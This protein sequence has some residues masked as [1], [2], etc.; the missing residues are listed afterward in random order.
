MFSSS[1]ASHD[2]LSACVRKTIIGCKHRRAS[3]QV[4]FYGLARE[5]RVWQE[6]LGGP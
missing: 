4:S 5:R 6:K 1:T 3:V 2:K